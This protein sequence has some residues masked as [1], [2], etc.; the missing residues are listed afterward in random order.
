[1]APPPTGNQTPPKG[2]SAEKYARL[3]AEAKAPYKG[4]RKFIYGSVGASGAIGAFVFLT[5]LLAGRQVGQALPNFLLQLG[6]IAIVI[7]L[8]RL[9]SRK[10]T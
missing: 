3:K 7:I 2:M 10:S 9:E 1:M 6:V 4:L 8:F 5:Q